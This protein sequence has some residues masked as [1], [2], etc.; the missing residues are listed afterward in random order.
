[1]SLK[2]CLPYTNRTTA[3]LASD[4]QIVLCPDSRHETCFVIIRDDLE[5]EAWTS[6]TIKICK[7]HNIWVLAWIADDVTDSLPSIEAN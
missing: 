6:D 3:L 7:E 1:V 4:I 2:Q 5:S